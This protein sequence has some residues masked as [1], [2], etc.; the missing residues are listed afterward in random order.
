M[1]NP[2][3]ESTTGLERAKDELAWNVVD[4]NEVE[5]NKT[6]HIRNYWRAHAQSIIFGQDMSRLNADVQLQRQPTT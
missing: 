3:V 1:D 6:Q 5:R 2:P 4:T